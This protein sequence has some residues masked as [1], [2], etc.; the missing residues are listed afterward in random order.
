MWWTDADECNHADVSICHKTF[1][2]EQSSR[3]VKRQESG[4]SGGQL[5]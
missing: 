1:A 5:L 3:L 4:Q 2:A